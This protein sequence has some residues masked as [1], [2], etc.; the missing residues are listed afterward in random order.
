MP[1]QWQK[2][3]QKA[4][5]FR[6]RS[7]QCQRICH[8]HGLASA[9]LNTQISD[10]SEDVPSNCRSAGCPSPAAPRGNPADGSAAHIAAGLLCRVVLPCR[11]PVS[12]Q[13]QRHSER[14]TLSPT[15]ESVAASVAAFAF[16]ALRKKMPET[17]RRR[18][19]HLGTSYTGNRRWYDP[20]LFNAWCD[21][22]LSLRSR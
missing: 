17:H 15:P 5:K 20:Q 7:H 4:A 22:T 2:P 8:R 13:I 19:R 18:F 1:I 6:S 9:A 21:Q 14:L 12:G 3:R 10:P 11:G 16:D